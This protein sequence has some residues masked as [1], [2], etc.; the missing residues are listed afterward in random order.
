[1]KREINMEEIIPTLNAMNGGHEILQVFDQYSRGRQVN[2]V[3]EE[4]G[5]KLGSA[6]SAAWMTV[7]RN[8]LEPIK[9]MGSVVT[10]MGQVFLFGLWLGSRMERMGRGD[11][12]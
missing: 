1:M 8:E 3:L 7:V 9:N 12:D 2:E 5:V 6:E 11:R 10:A 4:L